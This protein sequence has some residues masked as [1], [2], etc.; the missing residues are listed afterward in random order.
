MASAVS[1]LVDVLPKLASCRRGESFVSNATPTSDFM[2]T[3]LKASM[4]T[5][6]S[7]VASQM[8]K[9]VDSKNGIEA[10]AVRALMKEARHAVIAA[11]SALF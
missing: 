10:D 3:Q 1:E 9:D 6:G 7:A 5:A 8:V 11:R 4:R 2:V